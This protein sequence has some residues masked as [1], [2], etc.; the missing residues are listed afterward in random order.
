MLLAGESQALLTALSVLMF[1]SLRPGSGT[2]TF[3]KALAGLTDGYAGVDGEVIYNASTK[4]ELE[5]G[6]KQV[7]FCSEDD[8]FYAN[9]KVGCVHL[10]NPPIHH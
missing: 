9:L 2:T 10:Y 6:K 5:A 7:L 4:Q 1:V 3:L 8:V